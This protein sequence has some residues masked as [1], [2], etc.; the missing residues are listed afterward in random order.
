MVTTS[1]AK[2]DQILH[3][4]TRVST[5]SQA[6]KGSSLQTQLELGKKKAKQLGFGYKHWDEGGRSSHHEVI[7]DRPVLAE[8]LMKIRDG[9]I[10]HLFVY[11]QSRI[12]RIDIV[13][14]TVRYECQKQNVTLYTKDGHFDLSNPQEKFLKQ[15]LDGIAEFENAIRA[16]RTRLGK[17]NRVKGGFWHGGPPPYG[18]KLV[19]KKLVIEK[20]EAIWIKRIYQESA[21]GFST[22]DVKKLLDAKGVLPRRRA[23]SWSIGSLQALIKNTHYKGVY[24]YLDKKS[25]RRYEVQCPAIVDETTWQSVQQL[26]TRVTSRVS[27]QN[28][29]KQFYLLRDLMVCGHCGTPMAG[30]KKASNYEQHYYCPSKEREW[31][32]NGGSETPWKRGEGCGM[33]RALNIPATDKLVWDAVLNIHKESSILKEEVKWK[34]LKEQGAPLAQTAV[35]TKEVERSITK[36]KKQLVAAKEAQAK[37]VL[38]FHSGEIRADVYEVALRSSKQSMD[39][40]EVKLA[41]LE[42]QKRGHE[43]DAKWV[44][45]LKFFGKQIEAKNSFNEEERKAYLEG[46]VT[47]IKVKYLEAKN[48][49]ELALQFNLPIVEDGVNWRD[50]I[51]K[52]KGYT[53]RKGKKQTKV[54]LSGVERRGRKALPKNTPERNDSVTVE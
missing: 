34:I 49:H 32:K 5:V 8:L 48:S 29:T 37:M 36:V 1:K 13:A 30:R 21:K 7:S 6:D 44:G 24:E 45:W 3:I 47:Q 14:T 20:K 31:V 23:G 53:L 26:K 50:P 18:Y 42:L 38:N 9:V 19:D 22:L 10:K 16:E 15:V 40:L 2:T 41:N 54:A 11:D 28:R 46:L 52:R 4:Y 51:D 25:G 27:Q 17:I 12:S 39:D 35:D 43:K 33:S